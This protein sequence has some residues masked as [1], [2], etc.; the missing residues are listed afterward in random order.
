MVSFLVIIHSFTNDQTCLLCYHYQDTHHRSSR[1]QALQ[2]NLINAMKQSQ[3]CF[4]FVLSGHRMQSACIS[5]VSFRIQDSG[6]G[7]HR[8]GN[9][10]HGGLSP[11]RTCPSP[12]GHAPAAVWICGHQGLS[13]HSILVCQRGNRAKKRG[14]LGGR[15]IIPHDVGK[16]S[17]ILRNPL[18]FA[19]LTIFGCK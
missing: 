12:S 10:D 6:Y 2:V 15:F 18:K 4:F 19:F 1:Y 11:G 17:Q 14:C 9:K 16:T 5:L 3:F 13:A 7:L 8:W